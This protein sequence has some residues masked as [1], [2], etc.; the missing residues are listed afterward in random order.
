[1]SDFDVKVL[2]TDDY[3]L[4][5]TVD[6]NSVADVHGRIPVPT[7]VGILRHLA[8]HFEQQATTATG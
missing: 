3:P 4:I 1:M 6:K 2:S 7:V 8:D 5:I